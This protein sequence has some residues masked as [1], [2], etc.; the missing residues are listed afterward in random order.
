MIYI[1]DTSHNLKVKYKDNLLIAAKYYAVSGP[2]NPEAFDFREYLRNKGIHHQA[3]I[4]KND[5]VIL[6]DV[7]QTNHFSLA[8]ELRDKL[9]QKIGSYIDKDESG[10]AAALLLGYEGCLDPEQELSYSNAG[11][12]HVLCVSGMHVALI[13]NLLAWLTGWMDKKKITRH[14]K[15]FLLLNLIWFYAMVTGFSPSVIR[16]AAMISFVIFGK[17][18]DRNAS[19]YNL[20]CGSCFLLFIFDPYLIRSTGFVLSFLAVCG[21][22]FYH[23]LILPLWVP[24]NK[25]MFMVWE[26]ISVSLAA[27]LTTFPLSMFLFHQF[28]NYFLIAN[29]IIIPLSTGVMYSGLLI[30]VT[31]WIPFA[32]IIF[33]WATTKGIS[34]LN[35]LVD[36]VASLPGALTTDIYI[37]GFETL[38]IYVGMIVFTLWLTK[39]SLLWL[40]LSMVTTILFLGS[41]LS[42]NYESGSQL[43]FTVYQTPKRSLYALM[44]GHQSVILTDTT[45]IAS[46]SQNPAHLHLLKKGTRLQDSVIISP[47]IHYALQLDSL[48]RV[49]ILSDLKLLR[50]N[51]FPTYPK[52]KTTVILRGKLNISATDIVSGLNPI[53]VVLDNKINKKDSERLTKELVELNIPCHNVKTSGAFV[54]NLRN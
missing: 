34:L 44:N 43:T 19:V 18:V 7:V 53:Q 33:G 45:N 36:R 12:L 14:F 9:L 16:A 52:V 31:D 39:K 37:S 42:S 1:R 5:L 3:F 20:L 10:V 29:L 49:V 40:Q 51:A 23:K 13:Y 54:L 22:I 17:W 6:K 32:G 30:L 4:D 21:I 38:M 47:D 35:L 48:H 15:Y 24:P 50:E 26:L 46:G 27:Q 11:V 25:V 28:P 41:K 8:Y 2:S